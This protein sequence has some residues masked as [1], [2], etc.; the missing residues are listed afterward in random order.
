MIAVRFDR[1][2]V[3]IPASEPASEPKASRP[4]DG[5]DWGEG[6]R[7]LASEEWYDHA[8]RVCRGARGGWD[9]WDSPPTI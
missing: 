6:A 5:R 9:S 7:R 4:P 8:S 3:P 1:V 2:P